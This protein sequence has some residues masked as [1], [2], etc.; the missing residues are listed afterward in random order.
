MS[1]RPPE[2][3]LRR[4]ARTV[5]PAL[6]A[7]ALVFL[8]WGC[9]RPPDRPLGLAPRLPEEAARFLEA[10]SARIVRVA[11]GVHYRYLW[12]PVGPWAV[13]LLDVQLDRCGVGL[14]VVRAPGA[15]GSDTARTPVTGLMARAPS[16]AVAAVNGDFFSH[17]GS[18]RGPELSST[19]F[20]EPG[21]RP[22]L[23]WDPDR[24]PWIGPARVVRDSLVQAG[25][26]LTGTEESPPD[27]ALLA[28]FPELLDRG[29][30]V[31]D[32]EAEERPS[33]A[34]V[35]HPR[36]VVGHSPG[37]G[38]LWI[39]VVDGRQG[40]YSVGMTLPEITGFLEALGATEALNLD[41]GGSS[42]MALGRR[43]VSRPSDEEGERPVVNALV[44]LSRASAC[45]REPRTFRW[46]GSEPG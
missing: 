30:R 35:R 38:R 21:E 12:S 39:V 9:G 1:E 13:H 16:G 29:R 10:D 42:V 27:A 40:S 5:V 24:G 28:G 18:P 19:G 36:T 3:A 26:R 11:P 22:V 7:L 44:V 34:G 31:G 20:R 43:A 15:P 41:G 46:P 32:L 37:E 25:G 23:A 4:P 2:R 14:A 33:F 6:I 8:A 17:E 45:S